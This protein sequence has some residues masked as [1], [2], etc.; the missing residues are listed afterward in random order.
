MLR[1]R[2]IETVFQAER[3]RLD[4]AYRALLEARSHDPER[5][6]RRWR[7]LAHAWR[8]EH[9]NDLVREH[10]T[11]YPVEASLPMDPR[12]RDYRPVRGASYRRLELDANWVLEHFPPDPQAAE[13]RT[14]PPARAP[15]EPLRQAFRAQ[16]RG[17]F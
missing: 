9:L 16:G 10:N 7:R 13:G 8:F 11:W 2:E 4:A 14:Q 3:R 1:L 17:R 5:F 6:S 15:R 12:T